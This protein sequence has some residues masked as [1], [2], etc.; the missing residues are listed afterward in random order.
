MAKKNDAE[1][2]AKA[3]ARAALREERKRN[4]Q[5]RLAKAITLQGL[6]WPSN[7]PRT[8]AEQ[9]KQGRRV[10]KIERVFNALRRTVLTFPGNDVY[11]IIGWA[12]PAY[13]PEAVNDPNFSEPGVIVYYGA[14]RDTPQA[15]NRVLPMDA[16]STAAANLRAVSKGLRGL[17]QIMDSGVMSWIEPLS[18]SMGLQPLPAQ[19]L[20]SKAKM[21][22]RNVIDCRRIL[23]IPEDQNVSVAELKLQYKSLVA[24]Y[25]PDK[26]D[27]DAES[28]RVINEA[29][30]MYR[31]ALEQPVET[32]QPKKPDPEAEKQAAKAASEFSEAKVTNRRRKKDV[33]DAELEKIIS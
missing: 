29:Y 4:E 9:R 18:K 32:E 8:P 33:V 3:A 27:G 2:A 7:I 21:P 31:K 6:A 17:S 5:E 10:N 13:S 26:G 11:C 16:F 14:D 30:A 28:L 24:K 12:I 22:M 20:P 1:R 19:P 25:H 23:E 15:W